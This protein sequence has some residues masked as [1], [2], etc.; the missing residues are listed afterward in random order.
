MNS[1]TED[2]TESDLHRVDLD[3]TMYFMKTAQR[4]QTLPGLVAWE[5]QRST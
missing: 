1:I 2:F 3:G 4:G 5:G